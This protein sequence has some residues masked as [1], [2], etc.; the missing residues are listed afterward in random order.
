M[1]TYSF[2]CRVI[3][4]FVLVGFL[5]FGSVPCVEAQQEIN[6]DSVVSELGIQAYNPFGSLYR[7]H[8]WKKVILDHE[9]KPH[10]DGHIIQIIMDGGNG[11]QDPPMLDGNP[12][13]DDSLAYGNFYAQFINGERNIMN[14]LAPGMFYGTIYF[15]PYKANVSIYLRLWE[16]TD[17]AEADYYQDSEKYETTRGNAGGAMITPQPELIDQVEWWFGPSQK[18]ERKR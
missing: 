4:S 9:G 12:G 1:M 15:I 18:I 10:K 11:I 13:G 6:A 16:A 17:P 8:S 2:L 3:F 5:F 14:G 7:M